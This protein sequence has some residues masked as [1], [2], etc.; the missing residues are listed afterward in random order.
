MAA[1][2]WKVTVTTGMP[3]YPHWRV[4]AD[5]RW[6]MRAPECRN[7]V[8]LVRL[9]HFVPRRQSVLGR[10]LYEASFALHAVVRR[11]QLVGADCIVG[12]VPSLGGGA[13]A[14]L[15]A[16]HH[17]VPF[18]LVFQ[19]LVGRAAAQSG[20]PKGGSA[21]VAVRSLERRI[22][23][24]AAGVAIVSEAFR[25][26]LEEA[27]VDPERIVHLPNWTHVAHPTGIV[28]STR[29]HFGWPL[30]QHVVLHAGNMGFKQE[31][32]NVIGAARLARDYALPI[33]FVL[34]GDGGER[35]HLQALAADVANVEFLDPQHA[36]VFMDVL[37]A[38]D[39]LVVNERATVIDM[40]L[41]SKIT[42][43]FASGRPVV[44]AVPDRGST[45]MELMRSGGAFLTP[46]GDPAGLLAAI[47][48]VLAEPTLAAALV[49]R[50]RAYAAERLNKENS[51][52]RYEQFILRLLAPA[53]TERAEVP[54]LETSRS[55]GWR[56]RAIS[57]H[58]PSV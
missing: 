16:R 15:I 44:A 3:H 38:A 31:L 1:A 6:R 26:H 46:A 53:D 42:S 34:M 50:A 25:P 36:D 43:Y 48:Q 21:A 33:R 49:D 58:R 10:G 32:G 20:L 39:V 18:G 57:G 28:S 24:R 14:G 37:A 56:R 5:Y 27:G 2:G 41:P 11:D 7:R 12:I 22:A 45:A 29:A 30:N 19:D 55:R 23:R 35:K 8:G 40:S 54:R 4:G 9:R 52:E 47:R 17:R 13:A 51:L